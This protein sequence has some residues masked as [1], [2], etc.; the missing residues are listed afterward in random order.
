MRR[1]L[2][3]HL[4]AYCE[5]LARGAPV[6]FAVCLGGREVF[7]HGDHPPQFTFRARDAETLD[8][9]ARA[10]QVGFA[11][12][13]I[14]G[15]LELDG[16]LAALFDLA[17]R[18]EAQEPGPALAHFARAAIA[19]LP[20][21]RRHIALACRLYAAPR[22][23]TR[24]YEILLGDALVYS[25]ARFESE[26][27][28]LARA[29]ERKLAHVCDALALAPGQS[30]LDIGCA[31]GELLIH[32]ARHHGVRGVGYTIDP[33]QHAGALERV[34]RAGLADRVTL[35]LADYRTA[36]GVH[37]RWVSLEMNHQLPLGEYGAY[38]QH[39][40]ARL[41]PGGRGLLQSLGRDA[42]HPPPGLL[43]FIPMAR[44]L[45]L[46][47]ELTAPLRRAG[48]ALVRTTDVSRQYALTIRGWN[49]GLESHRPELEARH[50]P[51]LVRACGLSMLA[52]AARFEVADL[53]LW[54]LELA[55]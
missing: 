33:R 28:P 6:G 46:F 2:F 14:T 10:G 38:F 5:R 1:G 29:Q 51:E 16:D 15:A 22:P 34:A 49:A 40:A 48:L 42:T 8:Q 18:P 20:A 7:R 54:Q 27:E 23:D 12:G 26:S 25:A 30:L 3:S 45:P 44:S 11:L 4:R 53:R 31:W 13:Y 35:H 55:R 39:A 47:G 21:L 43:A 36:T 37:D 24:F 41:K 50:G 17:L 32:A 9:L 52:T 19:A